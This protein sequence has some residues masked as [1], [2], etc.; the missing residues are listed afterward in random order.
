[1]K[2][3]RALKRQND[4]FAALFTLVFDSCGARFLQQALLE[5]PSPPR[6]PHPSTTLHSLPGRNLVDAK[7]H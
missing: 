6:F 1:V 4:R 3:L 5:R 2:S 7:N